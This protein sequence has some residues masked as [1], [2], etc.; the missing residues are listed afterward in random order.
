[1]LG[2]AIGLDI[3]THTKPISLKD[4]RTVIAGGKIPG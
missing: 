3:Q 2:D 1:V 4:L